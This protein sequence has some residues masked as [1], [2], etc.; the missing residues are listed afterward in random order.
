MTRFS[1]LSFAAASIV[2]SSA[3]VIPQQA[4]SADMP[5]PKPVVRQESPSDWRTRLFE[6]FQ[7]YLHRRSP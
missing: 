1:L 7:R 6:E 3:A 2:I 5:V 4:W